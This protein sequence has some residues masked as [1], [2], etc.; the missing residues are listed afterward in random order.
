MAAS[1]QQARKIALVALT[2]AGVW[3]FAC[4]FADPPQCR[5]H[6]INETKRPIQ[7]L[8]LT[9]GLSESRRP[10]LGPGERWTVLVPQSDLEM[11]VVELPSTSGRQR[12]IEWGFHGDRNVYPMA[13]VSVMLREEPLRADTTYEH[14]QTPS[15]LWFRFKRWWATGRW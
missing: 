1:Q 6:V 9:V 3:S 5:V 10:S 8:L 2:V 13:S 12:L 14:V 15:I 7:E 11:I 4:W